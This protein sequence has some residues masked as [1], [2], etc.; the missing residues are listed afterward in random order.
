MRCAQP[1]RSLR[2]SGNGRPSRFPV[3]EAQGLGLKWRGFVKTA[4]KYN[5]AR[6]LFWPPVKTTEWTPDSGRRSV[7][8]QDI[9]LLFAIFDKIVCQKRLFRPINSGYFGIEP[10]KNTYFS[11]YSVRYDACGYWHTTCRSL[12]FPKALPQIGCKFMEIC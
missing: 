10:W 4:A 7:S 1:G 12:P 6:P 5:V 3:P 11:S 9:D 8:G 2:Q